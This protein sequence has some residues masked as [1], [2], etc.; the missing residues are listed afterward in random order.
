MT[1]K[2]RMYQRLNR[3]AFGNTI[4]AF[5]SLTAWQASADYRVYPD[6]GV[7]CLVPGDPR[8]RLYVPTTEVPAYVRQHF[9][10]GRGFN[11]S[12]MIDQWCVFKGEV[13]ECAEPPFGLYLFATTSG[14]GWREALRQHG[15][16]WRGVSAR[17]VLQ[18]YLDPPSYDNLCELL[19]LYLGHVVEFSVCDRAVGLIPGRNTVFWEVRLY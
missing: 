18:H 4:P 15:R 16:V 9:P 1:N 17:I 11:I 5:E 3:G 14:A 10:D 12:P 2:R 7:R 6:W 8:M 13:S 19:A